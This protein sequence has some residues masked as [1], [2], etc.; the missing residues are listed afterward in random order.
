MDRD[1]PNYLLLYFS[2]FGFVNCKQMANVEE[3]EKIENSDEPDDWEYAG[4]EIIDNACLEL[5]PDQ[6][7]PL[8][9]AKAVKFW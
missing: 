3:E 9:A 1:D 2:R 4:L 7:N 6:P 8:Q 5:Y